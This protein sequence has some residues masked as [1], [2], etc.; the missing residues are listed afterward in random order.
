[1]FEEGEQ[2]SEMPGGL[3]Q[4]GYSAAAVA[5]YPRVAVSQ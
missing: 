1:M 5:C 2:A 3:S 4:S